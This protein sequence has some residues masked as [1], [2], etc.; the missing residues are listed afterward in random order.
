MNT[1]KGKPCIMQPAIVKYRETEKINHMIGVAI[2]GFVERHIEVGKDVK[3]FNIRPRFEEVTIEDFDDYF[4]ST[5]YSVVKL[6]DKK[7]EKNGN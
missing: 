1:Y 6:L 5:I 4:M 2:A 3:L 7:V